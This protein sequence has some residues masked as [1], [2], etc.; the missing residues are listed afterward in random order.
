MAPQASS[1]GERALP[2]TLLVPQLLVEVEV[3]R[4]ALLKPEPVLLRG[5]AQEVGRLFEDVLGCGL[6]VWRG[7]GVGRG[8]SLLAA[9]GVIVGEYLLHIDLCGFAPRG[10]SGVGG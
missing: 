5:L 4:R 10:S 9:A 3:A 1:V 8:P 6:R 7:D 2:S